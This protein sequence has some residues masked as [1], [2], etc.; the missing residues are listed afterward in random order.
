MR[1]RLREELRRLWL[2]PRDPR[3]LQ[4]GFSVLFLLDMWLRVVGDVELR[5][6]PL[7]GLVLVPVAW[8]VTLTLPWTRTPEWCRLALLVFDV[9][10]V[11]LS[12]LDPVGGSA[13]LVL[14]PALWLGFAYGVRGAI[15]VRA[16]PPCSGDGA[17]G[18]IHIGASGIDLSRS[19]DHHRHRGDGVARDREVIPARSGRSGADRAPAPHR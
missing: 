10:L 13:M 15:I 8:V 14:I 12:R 18:W 19:A 2:E 7:V 5:T 11:G 9:G 1:G 4:L 6:G 16:S 17:S 3:L